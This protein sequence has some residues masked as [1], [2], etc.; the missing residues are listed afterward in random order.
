MFVYAIQLDTSQGLE[1][2]DTVV[3]S[4]KDVQTFISEQ[5]PGEDFNMP[6]AADF[7]KNTRQEIEFADEFDESY[8]VMY[9]VQRFK[10]KG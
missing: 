10:I 7:A 8:S 9:I 2:V 1:E 3:K 4:L 6:T 5:M